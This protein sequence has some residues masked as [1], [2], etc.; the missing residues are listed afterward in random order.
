MKQLPPTIC[1]SIDGELASSTSR[2]G[3]DCILQN[4]RA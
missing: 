1:T 4:D 3:D 2:G